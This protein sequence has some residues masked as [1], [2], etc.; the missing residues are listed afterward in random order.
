LIRQSDGR[1]V[2]ADGS[3]RQVDVFAVE[4]QWGGSWRPVL[5]S[6]MGDEVLAGMRLLAGHV[7][8]VTVVADGP[9]DITPL[10]TASS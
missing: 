5:V 7:L 4:V 6:A 9:V 10:V 1:A 2:L 3:Q 8:Q